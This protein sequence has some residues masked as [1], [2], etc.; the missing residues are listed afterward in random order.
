MDICP[1][2]ANE[3]AAEQKKAPAKKKQRF[4]VKR[5]KKAGAKPLPG[6]APPWMKG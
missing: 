5:G 3:M 1:E 4:I 6:A 2:C